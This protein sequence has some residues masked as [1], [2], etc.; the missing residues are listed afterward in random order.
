MSIQTIM[1]ADKSGAELV[2]YARETANRLVKNS[3]K[4]TQIRKIFTEVR[5][6]EALWSVDA[7]RAR[8]RLNLLKPKMD[9]QKSRNRE[10]TE[11][12]TVLCE[13]IDS[14]EKAK[15]SQERDE[16]FRRFV[17]LFEAILAYHRALGGKD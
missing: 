8:R 4:R 6:I 7:V 11:L 1:T 5:Q 14:V 12:Q 10:I 3:L 9:Y 13:A 16:R 17:E 2:R 15:D